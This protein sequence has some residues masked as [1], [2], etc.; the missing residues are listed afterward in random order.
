M[1]TAK[2][3]L[4]LV[5]QACLDKGEEGLTTSWDEVN[6]PMI[7]HWVQAMGDQNP[8]YTDAEFAT[9]TRHG[10]LVAPPTM[11][12]AWTMRGLQGPA[13][14]TSVAD[15]LGSAS[16]V[17]ADAGYAAVVA[18]NC[19]QAYL[20]YVRPGEKLHHKS[21]LESISDEKKTG[22][23]TGFFLT[24]LSEYFTEEG[25]KVAEMRFTILCYK[26]A[27]PERKT[28]PPAPTG[29]AS[30]IDFFWQG[31]YEDNCLLIQRCL[32]C[33][34]LRH[35]PSPACPNCRSLEHDAVE[36][37]GRGTLLNHVTMHH[38]PLP[39]FEHPASVALVE[40]DEGI[41]LL[42]GLVDIEREALDLGATLQLA[43]IQNHEELNVP[44]FRKAQQAVSITQQISGDAFFD[45]IAVGDKL[46]TLDIDITTLMIVSTAIASRDYQDVHH[47]KDRAQELGSPDI[48]MNILT[49]N[50]LVGRYV[51]DWAGPEAILTVV[52]IRLG[53]PNYPGDTM[54]MSGEV[55]ARREAD[56]KH[57]VDLAVVG[58]NSIGAHV[59]GTVTVDLPKS[60]PN[61]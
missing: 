32:S 40:L 34:A 1:H 38:A 27:A 11:L 45:D 31:L 12:Q 44:M 29:M 52:N 13:P 19:E 17:V 55:I 26:P 39:L 58:E 3:D 30:D 43:G 15:P 36:A 41:R 10:G 4:S 6:V 21:R 5:L 35:P 46:P 57:Y 37:S 42:A 33:K 22:L 53:A 9:S 14:G 47:D 59:S 48:F 49:S 54:V 16:S 25:E 60:A 61:K 23:G 56:G 2:S 8:I 50:G 24:Q 20:R 51:T 7:R 28:P 18:T